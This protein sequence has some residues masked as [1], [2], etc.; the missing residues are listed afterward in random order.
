[1]LR[2]NYKVYRT[3]DPKDTV[4][5]LS[6]LIAKVINDKS[7]L[8]DLTITT[9]PLNL[10]PPQPKQEYSEL[11]TLSKK[12][13]LTPETFNKVILLQIT[14]ISMRHVTEIQKEY[15]T[16]RNLILK[17]ESMDNLEER[18]DLLSQINIGTTTGKKRK[19]GFIMSKRIY[20]YF[21][22]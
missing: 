10:P 21:Y 5:F 19:M 14:G 16:I 22:P 1:M 17:Y 20:D 2:D 7:K 4:F 13:Q 11:V 9:T 6:R 3:R 15:P 8:L 18:Q 12:G